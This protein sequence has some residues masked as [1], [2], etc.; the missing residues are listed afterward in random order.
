MYQHCGYSHHNT[1][2]MTLH[3]LDDLSNLL[4]ITDG[5][6]AQNPSIASKKQTNNIFSNV[7]T[8]CQHAAS[9]SAIASARKSLD[10]QAGGM[11]STPIV[12]RAT[13]SL[14]AR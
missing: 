2:N 10:M 14:L 12:G 5:K 6:A 11:T 9:G 13:L 8:I 1:A 4:C 3:T 7:V